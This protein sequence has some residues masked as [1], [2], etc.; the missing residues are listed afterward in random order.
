MKNADKPDQALAN[1]RELFDEG[2]EVDTMT[3]A[4]WLWRLGLE[5]YASA[6]RKKNILNA[7]D[8]RHYEGAEEDRFETDFDIKNV[9]HRLRI[10]SMLKEDR[11]TKEDFQLLTVASARQIIRRFI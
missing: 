1:L 2:S 4:Q 7:T 3:T 11:L 6:F 5:H 8:M 10:V 9:M